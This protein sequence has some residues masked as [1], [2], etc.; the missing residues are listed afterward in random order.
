M[1]KSSCQSIFLN[2]VWSAKIL[3]TSITCMCIAIFIRRENKGNVHRD[4]SDR[5]CARP[6]GRH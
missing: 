3:D 5:N 1:I 4:G 2:N 6:I